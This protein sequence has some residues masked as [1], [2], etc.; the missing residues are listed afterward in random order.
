MVCPHCAK[1]QA[2]QHSG[3]GFVALQGK[4]EMCLSQFDD[5]CF[6]AIISDP[7]YGAGATALLGRLRPSAEKYQQSQTKNKLPDIAGD[8][9]LPEAW[10]FMMQAVISECY[11]CAKPGANL[12]LFCD[13]RSLPTFLQI[14]GAAGFGLKS[15]LVWNKG[16]SC[17][18]HKNGFRSQTEFIL[19]ARK[20]GHAAP[21]PKDVYLDGVFSF[22]TLANGKVHV[23]EKPLSLMKELMRIVPDGG[24][25]LDPFQGSGT[26]GVAAMAAGCT[27]VGIEATHHYHKIAVEKLTAAAR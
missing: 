16:R 21:R 24:H 7:P 14:V 23:T 12:L 9:M 22:P 2:T 13:W 6:D 27:Y 11:R 15:T 19:W 20:G 17:R 3:K 18:P 5:G 26:T 1:A 4:A 25:V 10:A 8:S